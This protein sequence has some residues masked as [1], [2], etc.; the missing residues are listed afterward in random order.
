MVGVRRWRRLVK[1]TK[2]WRGAN[3]RPTVLNASAFPLPHSDLQCFVKFIN[4]IIAERIQNNQSL[5]FSHVDVGDAFQFINHI[6]AERRRNT[7]GARSCCITPPLC[8]NMIG[9]ALA[10]KTI[11]RG[12]TPREPFL[13]FLHQ[14]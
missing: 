13:F 4:N 8:H 3:P 12:F 2:R 6:M 9:R 7:A 5:S 11:G 10:L 1:K 14:T